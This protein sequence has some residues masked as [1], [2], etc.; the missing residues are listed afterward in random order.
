MT[1][2]APLRPRGFR[3]ARLASALGL[4][5]AALTPLG[6]SLGASPA[7]AQSADAAAPPATLVADSVKVGTDRNLIADG[8]VEVLYQGTRM[9]ASRVVYDR[10]GDRLT[11]DGP[12]RITDANGTVL[13]A[14]SAELSRDLRNGLLRSARMVLDQQLQLAARQI[15]RV[16]GRYSELSRTVVSSCEVCAGHPRPLWEI[17]AARVVYDQQERQI[18]FSNATLR[19]GGVPV[20]YLP[21]LRMP[22]PTLKRATGF[23]TPKFRNTS[24][25]G[26]GVRL[27]YFIA[28]GDHRDLTLTPYLSN[29]RTT[30]LGLR[31]RQ[32]FVNGRITATGALGRDDILP[33]ETRGYLFADGSFALRDG[34]TLSFNLETVSDA[35]YL[36]D[37]GLPSKDRLQSDIELSRTRRDQYIS[38]RL[39]AFRSLR[40][41]EDNATLPGPVAVYT[42]IRRFRPALIGGQAQLSFQGFGLARRATSDPTNTGKARDMTRASVKLDW[43]RN[44]VT[45]PGIVVSAIAQARG[46]IY[47]IAQ[48]PNWADSIGRIAPAA[49]LELRWPWVKAGRNGASQVIEPVIQLILAPKSVSAAPNEDSTLVEFDEGNLWALNRFAGYDAIEQ[50]PRANVGLRWTRQSADGWNLGVVAGRVFR[51]VDKAQFSTGSGLGGA[52]SNWLTAVQLK[53]PNGLSLIGRALFD[54][55]FSVTKNEVRLGWAGDR[56]NFGT[57]YVWLVPDPTEN[58]LT[59]TAEWA[60]DADWNFRGNWTGSVAWRYDFEAERATSAG[61]NL[62]W[63][64]ECLSVDLSLSR[65]FT[66]STSVS[67]TTDFGLS[68]DL[69]G[70]SGRARGT[71]AYRR[72]CSG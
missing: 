13:R 70:I 59:K 53:T 25:L 32:A 12:I 66:S 4:G 29:S 64:N 50:G 17:R 28:I 68:V 54:N 18:Y 11:I 33:G 26:A 67:A 19:L 43:R 30:T 47:A 14:D 21:R 45:R 46:D 9:T 22:D 52:K 69:I 44:W 6:G 51:A 62:N 39:L 71:G 24:L 7:A 57:S 31:Y 34:Y 20:F 2:A 49:A 10:T 41:G 63:R 3:A 58:R 1:T 35:A 16:D 40:A 60:L 8:H 56:L 23:L 55:N 5:L 27:P 37:Y 42:Q 61:L 36:L 15:T 72:S 48:D 65:R 38:T